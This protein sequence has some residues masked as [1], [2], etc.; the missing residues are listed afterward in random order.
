MEEGTTTAPNYL[1]ESDL[2]SLMEKHGI[3]TDATW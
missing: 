3:G 1:E 2:L